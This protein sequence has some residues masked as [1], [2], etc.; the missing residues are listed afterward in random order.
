MIAPLAAV[1]AGVVLLWGGGEALV[2]GAKSL[3]RVLGMSP[4]VVGLTVVAF[5]TSTP[6]LAA[7]LAAFLGGSPDVGLGNVIGSNIANLGLVLGV[8]ALLRPLVAE[9]RFLRREMPFMLLG[10]LLSVILL[11]EGSLGLWEGL[12]LVALL[13]AYLATILRTGDAERRR[14]REEYAAEFSGAERGLGASLLLVALGVVLLVGGARLLVDGAVDLARLLGVAER[15]I[16]LTLVALGTSLPELASCLVAAA[17]DEGDIVLGNLIGSNV[18]NLLFVLGTCAVV[19]PFS[20]AAPE[21][22][23]DLAVMLGISLLAWPLLAR[24]RMGRWGGALMLAVYVAYIGF[25]VA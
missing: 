18:F 20:V 13:G 21:T 5:A 8:S 12:L 24:R 7:T 2:S 23:I 19:S 22:R 3:A 4:L 25:V 11:W 15:V 10:T 16:G 14:V 9:A 17:K 1:T 6:E